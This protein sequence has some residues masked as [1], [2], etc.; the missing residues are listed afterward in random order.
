MEKI[1]A[2]KTKV[3]T[4]EIDNPSSDEEENLIDDENILKLA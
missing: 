1:E 3:E 4:D 2:K